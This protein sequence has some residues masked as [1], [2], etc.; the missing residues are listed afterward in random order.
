VSLCNE[1]DLDTKLA[2]TT[3]ADP[4]KM[5]ARG[6]FSNWND[7]LSSLTLPS[8]N[9]IV[10]LF[11][12]SDQSGSAITF[13]NV[14]NFGNTS[15]VSNLIPYSF[16]DKL[17]SFRVTTTSAGTDQS[18]L[19]EITRYGKCVDVANGGPN[20]GAKVQ[21]WDCERNNTNMVFKLEPIGDYYR[22]KHPASGRCLDVLNAYTT[23]GAA[24]QLWDCHTGGNQLW[25][26]SSNGST[27][28]AR[29]FKL[30]GAASGK[31]L[32]LSQG[33]SSNGAKMWIWTCDSNNTN[34][35]FALK[36]F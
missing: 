20:N 23:D 5:E 12:N 8:S 29:D 34:Q 4:F 35:N 17:S 32:D 2:A 13:Q 30:V 10:T 19:L 18:W 15:S 28:D 6:Y 14:F 11:E 25:S 36:Q 1:T 33:S 24:I 26:I 16:N 9:T 3:F 31:C 27:S 21:Q 7:Q 22:I